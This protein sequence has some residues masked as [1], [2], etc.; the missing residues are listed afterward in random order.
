MELINLL[1]I[2]NQGLEENIVKGVRFLWMSISNFCQI[3]V[4]QND[5]EW[6]N[7][8]KIPLKVYSCLLVC[9]E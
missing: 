9:I 1:V 3:H 4:D 7:T 6:K 5:Q 2:A 8:S